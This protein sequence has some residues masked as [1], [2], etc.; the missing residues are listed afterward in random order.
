MYATEASKPSKSS[1]ASS[2]SSPTSNPDTNHKGFLDNFMN[3]TPSKEIQT[4][5]VHAVQG[6]P[7]ST[8]TGRVGAVGHIHLICIIKFQR[9]KISANVPKL[10]WA[11]KSPSQNLRA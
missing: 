10:K 3:I 5:I 7:P 4:S 11:R 2:E 6:N 9:G 1:G 8:A